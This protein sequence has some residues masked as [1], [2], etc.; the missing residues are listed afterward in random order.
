MTYAPARRTRPNSS[1]SQ[2][3]PSS[4]S[5]NSCRPPSPTCTRS[6][7]SITTKIPRQAGKGVSDVR[8]PLRR[9]L[10]RQERREDHPAVGA[11]PGRAAARRVLEPVRA[12]RRREG[13]HRSGDHRLESAG[14]LLHAVHAQPGRRSAV[15]I[16]RVRRVPA[17]PPV[18]CGASRRPA[19]RGRRVLALGARLLRAPSRP[20]AVRR[21]A[22]GGA[23]SVEPPRRRV[24]ARGR[25][26][27]RRDVFV[28]ALHGRYGMPVFG[29][30]ML[31]VQAV[32]FFGP[33]PPS[34][35]A[36]PIEA[37]A[38][39]VVFAAVARWLERRRNS[40]GGD[41]AGGVEGNAVG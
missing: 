30:V 26:A 8:R 11:V 9:E 31:I 13:A 28:S 1:R 15:V 10:R 4:R 35:T 34:A 23:R 17:D 5:R 6:S 36:A 19:R 38:F 21:Y 12:A 18:R 3:K 16:R 39:Y 41:P 33:P 20:A 7:R 29:V 40:V 25:G 27:V 22:E 32:V 24:P 37:L 14:P 2:P